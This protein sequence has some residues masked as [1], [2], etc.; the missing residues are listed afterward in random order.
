MHKYIRMYK[1][2]R[3]HIHMHIHNHNLDDE[4][5]LALVLAE[6]FGNFKSNFVEAQ[7]HNV[8]LELEFDFVVVLD[9]QI[10]SES[11]S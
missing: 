1:Y 10:F 8:I 4:H 6:K 2:V 5:V 9:C 7:Q 11:I 3:I